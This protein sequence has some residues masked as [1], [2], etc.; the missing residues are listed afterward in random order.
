VAFM[1]VARGSMRPIQPYVE[2]NSRN[3]AF[4]SDGKWIA[5]T[6]NDGTLWLWDA[7]FPGEPRRV[8]AHLQPVFK[9]RF[10]PDGSSLL[11]TSQDTFAKLIDVRSGE[12]RVTLKHPAL[13]M[14]GVFTHGGT[15]VLTTTLGGEVLA[16]NVASGTK[17]PG[18]PAHAGLA[19]LDM[20]KDGSRVATFSWDRTARV[21][22][23]A[24]WREIATFTHP[25]LVDGGAISPD[26]KHLATYTPYDVRITPIDAGEVTR[27]ARSRV[28]RELTREECDKF[29]R[30]GCDGPG[31]VAPA[32]P[33]A[34][35]SAP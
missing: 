24:T 12:T 28:S 4:S 35:G 18:P 30:V 10:S 31:G 20:S 13:V 34:P 23:T 19:Q 2:F 3:V 25:E 8:P 1:D 14:D 16:W 9:T 11:T 6:T 29:V 33:R 21:W 27:L 7:A 26:G 22:D 32:G 15:Q 17:V 5:S